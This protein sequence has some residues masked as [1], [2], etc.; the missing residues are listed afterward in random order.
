MVAEAVEENKK[1][2]KRDGYALSVRG[3]A[4]VQSALI[5]CALALFLAGG[6][7]EYSFNLINIKLSGADVLSG[8]FYGGNVGY[9]NYGTVL[10]L[11]IPAY[12]T[13]LGWLCAVLP[14]VCVLFSVLRSFV[15]KK[16]N[17]ITA[18]TLLALGGICIVM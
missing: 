10:Y 12:I 1:I 5:L 4:V 18:Y 13:L 6:F 7:V 15:F 11:H 16:D 8:S 2:K 3:K 14:L 9:M 17:S